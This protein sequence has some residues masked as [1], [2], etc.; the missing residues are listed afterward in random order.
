[1]FVSSGWGRHLTE[2]Y[3]LATLLAYNKQDAFL[4]LY[5]YAYLLETHQ[6]YIWSSEAIPMQ[7]TRQKILEHLRE[8]G[9]ST[10]NELSKA[11]DNLTAVTVRHHLDVLKERS[12]S[13]L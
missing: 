8:H 12:L 3:A 9:E 11:L 4:I 2:K 13:Q 7:K 6:G 5:D 10:V 1:M